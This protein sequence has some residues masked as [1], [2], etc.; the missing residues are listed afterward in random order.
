MCRINARKCE[1]MVAQ[2]LLIR[3]RL[4][5]AMQRAVLHCKFSVM[6]TVHILRT[7]LMNY[8]ELCHDKSV[9]VCHSSVSYS[10]LLLKHTA[11]ELFLY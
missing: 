11:C 9:T 4:L 8:Y 5:L 2:F 6:P 3:V 7:A 1:I 10:G